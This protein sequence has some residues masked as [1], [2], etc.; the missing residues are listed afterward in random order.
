LGWA[1]IFVAGCGFGAR[2]IAAPAFAP[3][4]AGQLALA[5]YDINKDG[6]LDA[7]EL[8]RCPALKSC[9]K[10]LDKDKD[11]RL[12]AA[13]I[14]DRIAFYRDS[15]VALLS[16]GCHIT[17][18]GNPL[19]GATVTLLPEKFLGPSLRPAS[20][21]SNNAGSV[22]FRTE[23][24]QLPG[25]QLGLYRVVVSKK[26]GAGKETIPEKYN[27]QTNLGLEVAPGH[28]G[29]DGLRLRLTSK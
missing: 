24:E 4:E 16:I 14:A 20:G 12:S 18:D 22:T 2:R 13:E 15:R 3:E 7:K 5:E 1:L 29:G 28:R 8:E 19:A 9:L 6:F 23:G 26:N 25:V 11:G 27:A 17:L 10:A 21:V